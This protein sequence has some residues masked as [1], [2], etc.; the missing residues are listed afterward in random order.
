[1]LEGA[2]VLRA[3]DGWVGAPGF[4]CAF[5][6]PGHARMRSAVL[7]VTAEGLVEPLLD[8]R[9]VTDDVLLPGWT[10][11][12]HR[13]RVAAYD[14]TARL[15]RG[16]H[17]I[18]LRA[19]NGWY[20]G[21]L[22]WM[23]GRALYGDRPGVAAALTLRFA[24]G[25]ST[26]IITDGSWSVVRTAT[27]FDDL[28][29]GEHIDLRITRGTPHVPV[30]APLHR[31]RLVPFE[32]PP[33]ARTE[34]IAPVTTRDDG[35]GATI[36]DFGQNLVGR[37]RVRARGSRGYRLVAQHAE[38]LER[39][40][41]ARRPLR[42]A[43]AEDVF[44]LSGGDDDLEPAFTFHGFRYARIEGWSGVEGEVDAVVIGSEL[45]RTGRFTCSDPA[46][47]RFHR[48]VVWSLRGN[49]VGIP[50]DC[51]QRDERLGWTGD[52]AVFAPTACFLFDMDGFLREWL[53]D[54]RWEQ[55][56]A[57][58][59]VPYVV[60]DALPGWSVRADEPPESVAI[61]SDAAVWVPWALWEA[62][63]DPAVLEE[64]WA[65]MTAHVERVLGRLS[66][67]GVWSDDFQFGD[68][69]DPTAPPDDP[70]A[71]IADPG[72]IATAALHR[73][74][75]LLSRA[76][77][78]LGRPDD[79]ERFAARARRLREDFHRAYAEPG[80]R[81][82]SDAPA[83]YALAIV[84][85]VLDGAE[86]AAAGDRLAA[87]V[88]A[89]GHHVVAGFAGAP[90]LCEALTR[91]GHLEVAHALLMN[92]ETPGW[93]APVDLG[94]TTVWER[95]DSLLPDGTVNPGEMTS[96]NHYAL[97]AVADWMHRVIG[98]LASLTPGWTRV[99]ID[100]RPPAG[101]AWAR[102]SIDT[103]R[104]TVS[105]NWERDSHGAIQVEYTA[106]DDVEIELADAIAARTRRVTAADAAVPA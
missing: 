2:A 21:R 28:Y 3:P 25:S 89:S 15:G 72:A 68:W 91:T 54:L 95:W 83:V 44:V 20:C 96:F 78:V 36:F 73:S 67:D 94:A 98:G 46:L 84:G 103:P 100:P 55:R 12:R 50:T 4:V 105:V 11:Y 93:L 19:G 45:R 92:R 60:P 102:T 1:M 8:G 75:L 76:A 27:V 38:V 31:S 62:S 41:L 71:A 99:R 23:G 13:L 29:D 65:S 51:P 17:E 10:A 97:G 59:R 81:L 16:S 34:V 58:G 57:D 69:L 77:E 64:S 5:E 85:E 40:E 6:V 9:S 7:E 70:F 79:E 66:A 104:G 63:G 80:G 53:A 14:I 56:D 30:V 48:N 88:R 90:Y 24:D 61:W 43:Q 18:E 74:I 22:G 52:I 42:S 47:D 35:R 37:L 87:L 49:T 86:A 106:P 101:L 39:G 26:R 33:I 82:R 32:G